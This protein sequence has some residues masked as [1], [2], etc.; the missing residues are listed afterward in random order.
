VTVQGAHFV[1]EDSPKAV[2][3]AIARFVAKV[4]AGQ[5]S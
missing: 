5:I 2:G 1:Q 4:H 3:E